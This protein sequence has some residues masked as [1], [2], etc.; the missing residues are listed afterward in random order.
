MFFRFLNILIIFEG[1]INKIL[2]EKLNIFDIIYFN[3]ILIYTK[4]LGQLYIEV[5]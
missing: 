2:I 3:N 4:N 1:Y 5:I